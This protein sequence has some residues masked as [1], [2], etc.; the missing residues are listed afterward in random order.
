MRATLWPRTAL[1]TMMINKGV[2]VRVKK[3]Y[4]YI[5]APPNR[6]ALPQELIDDVRADKA[7][8]TSDLITGREITVVRSYK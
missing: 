5:C 2:L 3:G 8:G 1:I 4:I 6:V 7:R